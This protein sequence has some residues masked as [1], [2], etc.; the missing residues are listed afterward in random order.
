MEL[1][2]Q[3][4]DFLVKTL[5]THDELEAAFRLRHE[6]FCEE[7]NWVPSSPDG[8]ES[9]RYD[10]IAQ[11]IGVFDGYAG[12]V[13]Y[14]R[15]ITAPKPFMIEKEFACLLPEDRPVRKSLD[16]AEVTRLCVKKEARHFGSNLNASQVLYKGIYQ[17]SLDCGIRHLVMVVE[18]KYY[19]LLRL[20]GFPVRS[21][22]DFLPMGDGVKAGIITLDWRS[23]EE[24]NRTRKPGL[25]EWISKRSDF[26]PS[27]LLRHGS[28]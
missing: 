5:A 12:L 28:Y 11:N 6:V 2:F 24:E 13:G 15:L 25:L 17:W 18:K 1:I 22:G 8:M 9:D 21:A 14:V 27:R 7:L 16:T 26:A 4:E 19:R 23:F 20:N 3:E 10:E